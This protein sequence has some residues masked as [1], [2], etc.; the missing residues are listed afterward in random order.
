MQWIHL[1]ASGRLSSDVAINFRVLW[2]TRT[3]LTR[4]T[5]INFWRRTLLHWL[6][7]INCYILF[8]VYWSAHHFDNWWI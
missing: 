2:K 1:G 3:L 5:T 6:R 8:D 7:T 4:Y